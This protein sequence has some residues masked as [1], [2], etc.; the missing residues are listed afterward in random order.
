MK[1]CWTGLVTSVRFG[2][3]DVVIRL[4]VQVVPSFEVEESLKSWQPSVS[5]LPYCLVE[6]PTYR[7]PLSSTSPHG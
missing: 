3:E 7:F 5:Q 2:I 6:D 4:V 1:P